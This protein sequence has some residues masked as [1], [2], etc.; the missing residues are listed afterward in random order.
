MRHPYRFE[1]CVFFV[2][3]SVSTVTRADPVLLMQHN[4]RWENSV[5]G[6]SYI[7]KRLPVRPPAAFPPSPSHQPR[8]GGER[9][10]IYGLRLTASGG[11]AARFSASL[12]RYYQATDH[13]DTDAASINSYRAVW[14]QVVACLS[15]PRNYVG[16]L[17]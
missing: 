6:S 16:V 2:T 10:V 11:S 8:D 4:I 1:M 3:Y 12:K 5:P 14:V 13:L 7:R 9:G 17:H 15:C